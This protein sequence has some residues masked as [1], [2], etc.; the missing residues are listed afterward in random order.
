MP[1]T[2]KGLVLH[3][4]VAKVVQDQKAIQI[5]LH[6]QELA[7]LRK[8]VEEFQKQRTEELERVQT[9]KDEE[10]RKLKRERKMFEKYQKEARTIPNKKDRDEI[11]SLK[12]QV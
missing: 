3:R 11:E 7:T 10:L 8:E 6:F 4:H 9:F 5:Y 2:D 12:T 1:K